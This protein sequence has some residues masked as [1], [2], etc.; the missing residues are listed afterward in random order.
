MVA[1]EVGFG[2]ICD[3]VSIWLICAKV[4]AADLAL[5]TGH[6]D[7]DEAAGVSEPL[8]RAAL[9][10]LLLLLGLNLLPVCQHLYSIVCGVE[11]LYR[12][13][14]GVLYRARAL[15]LV[16][17]ECAYLGCQMLAVKLNQEEEGY[18]RV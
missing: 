7:V 4:C 11:V 8:L 10:S 6:C 3:R 17:C 1:Y 18:V 5:A 12:S 13:R 14:D 15:W 2:F 16:W 9:G